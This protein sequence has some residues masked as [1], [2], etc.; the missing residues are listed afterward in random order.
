[1]DGQLL[2]VLY[3]ELFHAVKRHFPRRCRYDDN[4]IVFVYFIS[5]VADRSMRGAYDRR[6]WPLWARRLTRPG[7]SQVMR[8]L[9][10]DSVQHRLAELN[11]EYRARLPRTSQKAVDGKPLVVGVYSKDPD[12][13]WGKLNNR[14]W[15]RGDKVHARVDACGAVDAFDVTPLDAGESSVARERVQRV[16]WSGCDA[17]R[18][19]E[20]RLQ[21]AL[22]RGRRTW[23]T[24]AGAT[25]KA[26]DR[27]GASSAPSGSAARHR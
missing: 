10:S 6:H 17:A 12:A 3:H 2:R 21:C 15:A 14:D 4:V 11:A 27:V 26:A 5:V 24:F 13:R 8:R 23:R 7:Y 20:L 25:S 1:M 22:R 9:N 16:A 19:R 18:R